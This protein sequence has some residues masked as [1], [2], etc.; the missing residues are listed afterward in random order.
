MIMIIIK[1]MIRM[2]IIIIKIMKRLIMIIIIIKIFINDNYQENDQVGGSD[3]SHHPPTTPSTEGSLK[4]GFN[5]FSSDLD[6]IWICINNLFSFIIHFYMMIT[7]LQVN[8]FY[9]PRWWRGASRLT[10]GAACGGETPRSS[11]QRSW[12]LWLWRWS[13]WW[14]PP[15][16]RWQLT[17]FQQDQK[18][19]DLVTQLDSYSRLGIPKVA[20]LIIIIIH[21]TLTIF[22]TS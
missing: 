17:T 10:G 3:S 11:W 16:T 7:V 8:K 20:T 4:V 6:K 12:W 15:P 21:D 1:I 5:F 18:M 14:L 22:L 9:I 19:E 13:S 2:I